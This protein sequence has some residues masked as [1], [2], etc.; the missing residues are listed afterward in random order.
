MQTSIRQNNA[1]RQEQVACVAYGLW[2]KAGR[3]AG[4]DQEFWFKAQQQ[5]ALASQTGTSAT[6]PFEQRAKASP[7]AAAASALL[8]TTPTA[9]EWK[10][11][12]QIENGG[13]SENGPARGKRT[14][15]S[16]PTRSP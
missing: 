9:A 1:P 7:S 12:S 6:T 11:R 16:H 15:S 5:I 13:G 14:A 8:S 4:R 3:P 2:E 10:S